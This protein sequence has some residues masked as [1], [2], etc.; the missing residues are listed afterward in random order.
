MMEALKMIVDVARKHPWL[1]VI[2]VLAVVAHGADL[3]WPQLHKFFSTVA[4]GF[5]VIAFLYAS[6]TSLPPKDGP[7]NPP[8]KPGTT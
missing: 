7:S 5:F 8:E 2:L 1:I 4:Y 3:Q 6:G